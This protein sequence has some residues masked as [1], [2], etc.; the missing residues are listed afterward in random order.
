MGIARTHTFLSM[1][2]F[3]SVF[4]RSRVA[5]IFVALVVIGAIVVTCIALRLR[6]GPEPLSSSLILQ[7]VA[8]RM[9]V[10]AEQPIFRQIDDADVLQKVNPLFYEGVQNGDWILTFSHL[11]ILYRPATD[12]ILRTSPLTTP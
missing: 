10:P 3:R 8:E 7:R 11:V 5:Q 6:Q 4:Q 1:P 9:A 12:T 2:L